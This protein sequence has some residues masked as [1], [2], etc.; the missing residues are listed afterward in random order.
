MRD[1]PFCTSRPSSSQQETSSR[2]TPTLPKY[3]RKQL[4]TPSVVKCEETESD[5]VEISSHAF[6]S[7]T[8]IIKT[9]PAPVK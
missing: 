6:R 1:Y 5:I 8:H 3:L 2:S 7:D 4:D 9:E